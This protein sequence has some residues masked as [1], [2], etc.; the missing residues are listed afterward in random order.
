MFVLN[1]AGILWELSWS[2]MYFNVDKFWL[3]IH[4]ALAYEIQ[5]NLLSLFRTW[6]FC[7]HY[8]RNLLSKQFSEIWSSDHSFFSKF[9][10]DQEYYQNYGSKMYRTWD[11]GNTMDLNIF[12]FSLKNEILYC[13]LSIQLQYLYNLTSKENLVFQ[14]KVFQ[15]HR[16]PCI[17][18]LSPVL[19]IHHKRS[20]LN[21]CWYSF[22]IDVWLLLIFQVK[23]KK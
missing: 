5:K 8:V 10:T 7:R 1:M 3:Q 4:I 21:F 13:V 18:K 6:S 20:G 15:V 19:V 9:Y 16:S 11:I 14:Y 23:C 22:N 2:C 17:E 12:R